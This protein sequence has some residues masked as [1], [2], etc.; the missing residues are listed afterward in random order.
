MTGIDKNASKVKGKKS[1]SKTNHGSKFIKNKGRKS[2]NR[3]K[4]DKDFVKGQIK[5]SSEHKENKKKKEESQPME[6]DCSSD[7]PPDENTRGQ[8]QKAQKKRQTKGGKDDENKKPRKVSL[9]IT[10]KLMHNFCLIMQILSEY[11]ALA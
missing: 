4:K 7:L 3:T 10:L 8:R 2:V 5:S 9:R 11:I 1:F 6:V